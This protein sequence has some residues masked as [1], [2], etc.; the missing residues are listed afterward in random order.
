MDGNINLI[1][2][3]RYLWSNKGF[4][5]KVAAVFVILG[6]FYAL[7]S[8]VE[9]QAYCK[10]IPESSESTS[11]GLGRLGSLAGLAG[12]S[13]GGGLSEGILTPELYPEIASSLP[14]VIELIE[15]P[16]YFHNVDSM[17]SIKSYYEEIDKPTV[18][19]YALEYTILLPFKLKEWIKGD[20]GNSIATK[21]PNPDLIYLTKDEWSFIE[22][23]RKKVSVS[24]NRESGTISITTRMPDAHAA[25]FLA[26]ALVKKLTVEVTKYKIEKARLNLEFVS[27]RFAEAESDYKE[28]QIRLA[29]FIDK[30]RSLSSSVVQ[31]EQQR[32]TNELD[33]AFE[34]FKGLA[35]QLEQAKIKLKED[36]P[37]FT[38]LEPVKVPVEKTKP[39][40]TLIVIISAFLGVMAA[41]FF[42]LFTE[43]LKSI[44][45]V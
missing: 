43:Y 30:N 20:R 9:Y 29:R 22:G 26:D 41:S 39:R 7:T 32:L 23:F 34:L 15:E 35:T 33:V 8:K 3:I 38:T 25:A 36:T 27:D 21:S 24:V 1:V 12:I 16:I 2:L 37:V 45:S 19:N 17:I 11:P 40:R 28:K 5:V 31:T 6:I 10:V 42:L 14:F 18:L 4:I 13:L 44:K